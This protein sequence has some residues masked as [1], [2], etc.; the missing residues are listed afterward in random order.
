[1]AT[2][3]EEKLTKSTP[4]NES[5][6]VRPIYCRQGTRD[7]WRKK[8]RCFDGGRIKIGLGQSFSCI[9]L[10]APTLLGWLGLFNMEKRNIWLSLENLYIFQEMVYYKTST[11]RFVLHINE[12]MS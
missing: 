12:G 6:L 11:L 2:G 7:V 3:G 8:S 1:M 10:F 4:G 5:P 9:Y